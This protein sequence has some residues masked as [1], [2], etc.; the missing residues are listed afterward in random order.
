MQLNSGFIIIF[1]SY[2]WKFWKIPLEVEILYLYRGSSEVSLII[3]NT[4]YKGWWEVFMLQ[5]VAY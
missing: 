2:V 3:E 5:S 1:F 4:L